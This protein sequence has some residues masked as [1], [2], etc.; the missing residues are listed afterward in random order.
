LNKKIAFYNLVAAFLFCTGF[1][2]LVFLSFNI[3][4]QALGTSSWVFLGVLLL[5]LFISIPQYQKIASQIARGLSFWKRGEIAAVELAI[6]GELNSIQEELNK[7][8]E[9]LAPFPAEVEWLGEQGESFC[10]TFNG[11]VIV[12]M[13]EHKHNPRNIAL[14]TLDYITKGII[15]YSRLYLDGEMS[16]AIDF[17]MGKKILSKNE[18]ALDYFYREV[19]VPRMDNDLLKETMR[20]MDNLEKRGIFTR[21]FLDEVKEVGLDLY[22]N[23]DEV[24]RV[25]TREF[26]ESL[27]VY[28]T[29]SPG[30]K[31]GEPYI[32]SRIKV[33]LVL[34]ADPTKLLTEGPTPYI[35]WAATCIA[36]GAKTIYLLSRRGKNIPAIDLAGKIAQTLNLEIVKVNK[37]EE[38][39]DNKVEKSLCIKLTKNVP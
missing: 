3:Y 18:S 23:E 35:G 4:L 30:K 31:E 15:P 7:E 27:N 24:A 37:F 20:I 22:P 11:R 5:H 39:V 1:L 32:K 8:S 14:A 10:D 12:R 19:V 25:E 33:G 17:A 2:S 36:N 16:D 26:A 9:G 34:I 13:K 29:R 6:E 38:I 21:V 28:A